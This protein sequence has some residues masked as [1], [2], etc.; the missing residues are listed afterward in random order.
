MS[1][2]RPA[3]PRGEVSKV[4]QKVRGKQGEVARENLGG[5]PVGV[6]FYSS[7]HVMNRYEPLDGRGEERRES[8]GRLRS[9]E[10]CIVYFLF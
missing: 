4:K 10:L 3:K 5:S 9:T 1:R 2:T 8:H 7:C 6:W